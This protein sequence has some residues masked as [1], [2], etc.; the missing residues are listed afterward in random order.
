MTEDGTVTHAAPPYLGLRGGS[1][2]EEGYY[3]M[4]CY[5]YYEGRFADSGKLLPPICP[6]ICTPFRSL[7]NWKL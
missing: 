7:D 1:V 4:S 5:V 2:S 3:C 6:Q